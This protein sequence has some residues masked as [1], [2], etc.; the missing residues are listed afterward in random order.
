MCE[1]LSELVRRFAGTK[2]NESE[3]E[4]CQTGKQGQGHAMP[5]YSKV[6]YGGEN[7]WRVPRSNCEWIGKFGSAS[8]TAKRNRAVVLENPIPLTAFRAC[9]DLL[10]DGLNIYDVITHDRKRPAS[11]SCLDWPLNLRTVSPPANKSKLAPGITNED[12]PWRWR[13]RPQC[14]EGQTGRKLESSD[15][16]TRHLSGR[17]VPP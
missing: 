1:R 7:R 2:E 4:Q 3:D 5:P 14:C 13:P 16:T 17:L 11:K 8:A 15:F 12:S 9:N 6:P 10:L